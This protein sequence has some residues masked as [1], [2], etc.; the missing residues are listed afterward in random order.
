MARSIRL[1]EPAAR[2]NPRIDIISHLCSASAGTDVSWMCRIRQCPADMGIQ[3]GKRSIDGGD[4]VLHRHS[5]QHI[6][7]S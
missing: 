7:G 2:P 6:V 4:M 5:C 3:R 1:V